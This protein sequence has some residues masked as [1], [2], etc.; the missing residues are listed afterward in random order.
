MI[1]DAKSDTSAKPFDRM[2]WKGTQKQLAELFIELKKKGWIEDFEYE[3]IKNCFTK[4]NTIHQALKPTQDRK[5]KESTYEG[6]YSRNYTPLFYGIREN[7][8]SK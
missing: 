5:T 3:A 2:Q 4:S 7:P 1:I 6:V 8:K